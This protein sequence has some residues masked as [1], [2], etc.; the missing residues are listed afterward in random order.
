MNRRE[1]LLT[2][3]AGAGLLTAGCAGFDQRPAAPER[4]VGPG[5]LKLLP[6]P[7]QLHLRGGSLPLGQPRWVPSPN[8]P[9][10]TERL[11][12]DTLRR[13]SPPGAPFLE[14]R[15]GSVEEG[16]DPNW[17]APEERQFLL[18]EKTSAEASILHIDA[19]GITVVGKGRF[20]ML[21]GVQ[22][23]CQLAREA[24]AQNQHRLPCLTARDWPDLKWRCLS[25]TLTW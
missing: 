22:T 25:P 1:F 6:Y 14:V 7:Q 3:A 10:A 20:G 4:G 2:S 12:L 18:S 17:L 21:Y 9:T 16:Y 24:T 11:A 23:V 5:A 8:A 15:L 13:S 19:R